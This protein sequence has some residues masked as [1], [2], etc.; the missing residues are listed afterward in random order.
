M[1]DL[2]H[3][4][5][6]PDLVRVLANLKMDLPG[7]P[8]VFH[9]GIR[10]SGQLHQRQKLQPRFS[11]DLWIEAIAGL[12]QHHKGA[13]LRM[14]EGAGSHQRSL[15]PTRLDQL[16]RPLIRRH[17]PNFGD[18]ARKKWVSA[19]CLFLHLWLSGTT[20]PR[21]LRHSSKGCPDRAHRVCRSPRRDGPKPG[22]GCDRVVQSGPARC[23]P[24][25]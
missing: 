17:P 4:R 23:T 8:A 12:I 6:D 14:A 24:C 11:L 13:S 19:I 9:A 10:L 21:P 16:A 3:L 1:N 18:S 22:V 25:G 2:C 15:P 20:D 7:I 5:P